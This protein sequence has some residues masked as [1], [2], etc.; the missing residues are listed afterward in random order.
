[1][2]KAYPKIVV[3]AEVQIKQIESQQI[4]YHYILHQYFANIL[5]NVARIFGFFTLF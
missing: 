4:D 1:M 3:F 5:Q 2:T